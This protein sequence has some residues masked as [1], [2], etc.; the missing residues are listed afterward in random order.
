MQWESHR[1]EIY[2]LGFLLYHFHF[3]GA[4][5]DMRIQPKNNGFTKTF[6]LCYSKWRKTGMAAKARWSPERIV[7]CN[8][9]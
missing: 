7:K 4:E 1:L 8:G 9:N 5:V 6:N 2:G 3:S